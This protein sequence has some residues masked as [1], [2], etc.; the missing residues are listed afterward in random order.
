MMGLP[1]EMR[2]CLT[3]I[4]FAVSM[5]DLWWSI[6]VDSQRQW[7]VR[8]FAEHVDMVLHIASHRRNSDVLGVGPRLAEACAMARAL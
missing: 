8:S 1:L 5:Y 7:R 6:V 3:S 4:L 2:R